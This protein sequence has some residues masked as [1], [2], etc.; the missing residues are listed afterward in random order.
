MSTNCPEEE[1]EGDDNDA[2]DT[3][4]AAKDF[5][6]F[7]KRTLDYSDSIRV[8]WIV[9]GEWWMLNEQ[10]MVGKFHGKKVFRHEIIMTET[11]APFGA[12]GWSVLWGTISSFLGDVL[13]EEREE[14][15]EDKDEEGE[16][17]RNI[18][19]CRNNL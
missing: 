9:N 3:S 10:R 1:A 17:R 19:W 7:T 2:K 12:R 11:P 8:V 5:T 4:D 16:W 18:L 6:L 14:E 15:G 13:Q